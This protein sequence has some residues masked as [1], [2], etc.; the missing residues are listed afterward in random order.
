[1]IT[2]VSEEFVSSFTATTR[3]FTTAPTVGN[4][5]LLMLSDQ[6][7]FNGSFS[8]SARVISSVTDNYGN[9]YTLIGKTSIYTF[10]Y[11]NITTTGAG[12]TVTV[13]TTNSNGALV[14]LA[15]GRMFLSRQFTG[16]LLL[17]SFVADAPQS[18][19]GVYSVSSTLTQSNDAIIFNYNIGTRGNVA[20]TFIDSN[21]TDYK[22]VSVSINTY[23]NAIQQ[24]LVSV[25]E[26]P[27]MSFTAAFSATNIIQGLI[28]L[29]IPVPP[30]C[31]KLRGKCKLRAKVKLR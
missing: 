7:G 10:Y 5:L 3:V 8:P 24:R 12:F 27:T 19:T 6:Q 1:M 25:A 9:T 2:Y 20:N 31:V 4:T 28:V 15:G 14:F 17:D 22:D 26:V 30:P 16:N 11:A 23:A 21:Y 18:G 29:H 13:G